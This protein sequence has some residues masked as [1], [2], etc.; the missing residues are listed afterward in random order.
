MLWLIRIN[1]RAGSLQMQP[2][3]IADGVSTVFFLL[4]EWER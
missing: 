1:T 2:L 3:W 4:R